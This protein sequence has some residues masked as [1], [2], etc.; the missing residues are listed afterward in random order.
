MT[1]T[2]FLIFWDLSRIMLTLKVLSSQMLS[3]SLHVFNEAEHTTLHI[4]PFSSMH[5]CLFIWA[6]W[7]M[8]FTRE[9]SDASVRRGAFSIRLVFMADCDAL[10]I[11]RII[12]SC[13][14]WGL[15]VDPSASPAVPSL[16][17]IAHV[18]FS[19]LL[20]HT[21]ITSRCFSSNICLQC[22]YCCLMLILVPEKWWTGS[23]CNGLLSVKPDRKIKGLCLD[24]SHLSLSLSVHLLCC[25][26]DLLFQN[27]SSV[28]YNQCSRERLEVG[29]VSHPLDRNCVDI[30]YRSAAT[31]NHK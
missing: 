28:S 10:C 20:V 6:Y 18:L 3:A 29:T 13:Q 14:M 11:F 19:S 4:S 1:R 15:G 8:L 25:L 12:Y 23:V 7:W 17:C 24:K 2:C 16:V 21:E 26:L 31:Q 30:I 27:F 22:L 5:T 9:F